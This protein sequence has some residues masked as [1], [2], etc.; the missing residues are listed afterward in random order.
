[1]G[2][3]QNLTVYDVWDMYGI[4]G[5]RFPV[6]LHLTVWHELRYRAPLIDGEEQ[7]VAHEAPFVKPPQ[8]CTALIVRL[9]TTKMLEFL[10]G[11]PELPY[12]QV[13]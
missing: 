13:Q 12:L 3:S 10:T 7:E 5:L 11:F 4:S 8:L 1:M 9:C 6:F 2:L